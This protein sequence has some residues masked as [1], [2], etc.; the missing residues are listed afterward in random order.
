MVV[1]PEEMPATPSLEMNGRAR[2]D[3]IS[4][5]APSQRSRVSRG[6]PAP[7][8][9]QHAAPLFAAGVQVWVALGYAGFCFFLMQ[10]APTR[11]PENLAE[12]VQQG[13]FGVLWGTL[14]A[15]R[16]VPSCHIC[17]ALPPPSRRGTGP[18]FVAAPI[19]VALSY[20]G[21][22]DIVQRRMFV[23]GVKARPQADFAAGIGVS[24]GLCGRAAVFVLNFAGRIV[25]L[26]VAMAITF[27]MIVLRWMLGRKP[28]RQ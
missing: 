10:W 13:L 26:L 12:H 18:I 27:T 19:C 15:G 5:N 7:N 23:T 25:L 14:D 4:A 28:S 11:P 6:T 21:A 16:G 2:R 1:R 24:G 9:I 22:S 20:F 3:N 17:R 8:R